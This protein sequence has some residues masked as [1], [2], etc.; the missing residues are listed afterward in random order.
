[1]NRLGTAQRLA[2]PS[3]ISESKS[4]W[5]ISCW[6]SAL[7]YSGA[8]P[9]PLVSPTKRVCRVAWPCMVSP[10]SRN[11][12][13]GERERPGGKNVRSPVPNACM[14][15]CGE[16]PFGGR[17]L[18]SVHRAT[19]WLKSHPQGR[20]G[21]RSANATQRVARRTGCPGRVFTSNITELGGPFRSTD[22]LMLAETK[23]PFEA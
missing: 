5:P 17:P 4:A 11:N 14:T 12:L 19:S 2:L 21:K 3:S 16:A 7:H 10:P 18:I 23:C 15:G 6:C 13:R 1:V 8:P 22:Q 9:S 20:G